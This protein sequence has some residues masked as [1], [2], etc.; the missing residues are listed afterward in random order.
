VWGEGTDKTI[1]LLPDADRLT[2]K[3]SL[4]STDWDNAPYTDG[5]LEVGAKEADMRWRIMDKVRDQQNR[6]AGT[7]IALDDKSKRA[8]IEVTLDR[9]EVAALGVTSIDDLKKLNF[10]KLQGRYFRFLLPTFTQKSSVLPD[11]R[12]AMIGWRDFQ[13]TIKFTRTGNI[14][15]KTMDDVLQKDAQS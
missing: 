7:F 8:R 11:V 5:T 13:R 1:R 3:Q 6:K 2:Q 4:L 14:G 15:L 9:P 12:S 10:T